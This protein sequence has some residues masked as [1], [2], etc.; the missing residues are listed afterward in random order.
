MSLEVEAENQTLTKELLLLLTNW[1]SNSTF[2]GLTQISIANNRPKKL[3]WALVIL[4]SAS[5]CLYTISHVLDAFLRFP[6]VT[7]TEKISLFRLFFP[8]I[9]ICPVGSEI[10][11][12]S[13]IVICL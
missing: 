8:T 12:F 11:S 6:V 3:I 4:T 13:Q 7:N 1:I 9:T 2:H 5:Y 10:R